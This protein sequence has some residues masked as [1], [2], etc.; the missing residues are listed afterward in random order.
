[1]EPAKRLHLSIHKELW[2]Y[3]YPCA[4]ILEPLYAEVVDLMDEENGPTWAVIC[5][6]GLLESLVEMAGV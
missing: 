2:G 1:M 3:R 6:S 4:R 5:S